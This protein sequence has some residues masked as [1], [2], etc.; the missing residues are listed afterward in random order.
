[1]AAA[2][3]LLVACGGDGTEAP[4]APAPAPSP[5]PAPTPAPGPSPLPSPTASPVARWT[6][7][8]DDG[9]HW[10]LSGTVNTGYAVA[11]YDID[12]FDTPPA[13]IAAL[14]G[15]GRRVVCY[16]SAGSAENWR[17]DYPRFAA[18]DLGNAVDGWA[19]ERWVDVRSATVRAIM[20]ARLDLAVAKGCDAVEPDNV[21]AFE[22]DNRAGL[23]LTAAHQIDYN[24][25]L[26]AE[27]HRRG[28]AIAL[29]NDL[30]QVA[31]LAPDF[32]FAVNEQCHEY[33]EC[34]DL[35]PFGAAGKA[36]FNAEYA[37]RYRTNAGGARDRLCAA[38]AAGRLRTLVLPVALDDGF[39][40]AC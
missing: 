11:V 19:G 36:V 25:F 9:W 14:H 24:R 21:D 12:L 23:P 37:D 10:Q 35:S 27:A 20:A 13:T 31:T 32:D 4:V 3:L 2:L 5:T 38:A 26:A 39:R 34:S 7:R 40:F 30:A 15:A 6:P 33:D 8:P 28:L 1:M 17:S 16:F 18:A 29:K 22:P